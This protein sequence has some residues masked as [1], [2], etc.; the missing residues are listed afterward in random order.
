MFGIHA[1]GSQFGRFGYVRKGKCRYLLLIGGFESDCTSKNVQQ[2]LR[3]KDTS[4]LETSPFGSKKGLFS[5]VTTHYT[6]PEH[7]PACISWLQ[8]PSYSGQQFAFCIII[9]VR[10]RL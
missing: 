2:G 7:T 6:Y 5:E 9:T 8:I 3:L 10:S 4:L 1:T